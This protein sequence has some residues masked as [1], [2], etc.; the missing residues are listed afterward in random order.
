MYTKVTDQS[1]HGERDIILA[2]RDFVR[3]S[4]YAPFV[5]IREWLPSVISLS[6]PDNFYLE[7]TRMVR[8]DKII[9]NLQ[10][11]QTLEML[12]DCDIVSVKAHNTDWKSGFATRRYAKRHNIPILRNDVDKTPI[13]GG[14]ARRRSELDSVISK[15]LFNIHKELNEPSYSI[16]AIDIRMKV[17]N[18]FEKDQALSLNI[19]RD[20]AESVLLEHVVAD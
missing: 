19:V 10:N 7:N 16:S 20:V 6:K 8:I 14:S 2:V 11:H 17:L 9:Q 3:A 15:E 12:H 18:V 13:R 5:M 4:G 1:F